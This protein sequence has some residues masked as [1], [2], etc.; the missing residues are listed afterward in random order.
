MNET[1]STTAHTAPATTAAPATTSA[2][3]PARRRLRRPLVAF[4]V[5]LLAA[6]AMLVTSAGTASAAG[7]DFNPTL[8]L[9]Y[10]GYFGNCSVT[11]GPVVDPLGSAHGFAVIGGGRVNCNTRHTFTAWTQEFY[12]TTGAA[13]S[14]YQVGLNSTTY[15]NSYGFGSAILRTGRICGAGYWFTRVTVT[16]AGYSSVYFDS[17]ARYVVAA[18]RSAAAC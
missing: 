6:L 3:A 18:G 2:P 7:G 1:T 9:V 11:T 14:Y 10:S 16:A 17:P 8:S 15:T 5:S 13:R 12:S 4:V